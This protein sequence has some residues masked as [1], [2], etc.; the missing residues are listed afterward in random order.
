MKPNDAVCR[1]DAT[2]FFW[3]DNPRRN[4]ASTL[5]IAAIGAS[6]PRAKRFHNNWT[7]NADCADRLRDLHNGTRMV[8]DRSLES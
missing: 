2:S 5:T 8:Q 4:F 6:R 1:R 3:N 7:L